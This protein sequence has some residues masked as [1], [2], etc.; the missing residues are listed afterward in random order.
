MDEGSWRSRGYLPHF[1]E[2]GEVQSITFRLFDSVPVGV[3]EAWKAELQLTGREP[4]TDA[5]RVELARRIEKYEDAGHGACFLRDPRVAGLV[6][7]A[8]QFFDGERYFLLA[9]C[10]M[11]N[12]VH[13][14]I[15]TLEGHALED[16]LHSWKSYTAKEANKVLGRTGE[17]WM[18][19]YHD[20]YMR[21]ARHMG[22]TI[23]YIEE[24]PIAAGSVNRARDWRW[25]SAR[26]R[27]E[28]EL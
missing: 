6:E 7:Q 19:E 24:N 12:H 16:V 4:A 23:Q 13:V 27:E 25:C 14:L 11:A 28:G 8:L 20:R 21:D 26:L 5:K 18:K 22:N 9:W 10:V 2:P 1:D 17:F 15:E 3:L